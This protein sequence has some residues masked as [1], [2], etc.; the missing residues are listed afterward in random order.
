MSESRTKAPAERATL[1]DRVSAADAERLD[2]M[3]ADILHIA[4]KTGAPDALRKLSGYFYEVM[5]MQVVD[6]KAIAGAPREQ[7]A[8][9]ADPPDIYPAGTQFRLASVEMALGAVQ[10]MADAL[11]C[12]GNKGAAVIG[13][14]GLAIAELRR[15]DEQCDALKGEVAHG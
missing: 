9:P 14:I 11:A 2:A 1:P 4:N 7:T 15:I 3:H 13:I 10:E 12:A 8:T 6:T 5:Q